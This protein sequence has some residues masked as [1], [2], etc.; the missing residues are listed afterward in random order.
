MA[1]TNF[2]L[3]DL[4]QQQW[5][6]QPAEIKIDNI[7][8]AH[9]ATGDET[10][11][12]KLTER[13]LVNKK[14]ERGSYG[15]YYGKDVWGREVFMPLTLG[16]PID[17]KNPY[18]NTETQLYLPYVWLKINVAKRL[19]ETDITERRGSVI[20]LVSFENVQ[21]GV[22]GFAIGAFDSFPETEIEDLCRMFERAQSLEC[23]S[24]LTDIFLLNK[25]NNRTDRVV[26]RNLEI[27]DNQG[28][29]HVRGFQFDLISDQIL[30]L[31]LA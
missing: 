13:N 23:Q 5:G 21:I 9:I 18:Q 19:I 1:K 27:M 30:T 6:Y 11:K 2:N 12:I 4:F 15:S 16:A 7:D 10:G 8:G 24:V 14:S 25:K 26:M 28:I 20:E 3:N 22:K 17:R 29:E 31:E